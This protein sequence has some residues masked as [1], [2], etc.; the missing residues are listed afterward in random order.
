M[1]RTRAFGKIWQRYL[2]FH[3]ERGASLEAK[4]PTGE[5]PVPL[6]KTKRC[7]SPHSP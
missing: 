6:N 7:A 3:Y 5:A 2:A 1:T 4:S